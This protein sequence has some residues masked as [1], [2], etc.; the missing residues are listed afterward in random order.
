MALCFVL[1]PTEP[2][3]L[4]TVNAL[5]RESPPSGALLMQT[6]KGDMM[7]KL[8]AVTALAGLLA[9]GCSHNKSSKGGS[10]D[11]QSGMSSGGSYGQTGT[12]SGTSSGQSPSTTGSS[13]GS[14]S[15]TP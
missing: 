14:T 12:S 11:N 6:I 7:K 4:L 13:S 9:V 15:S 8:I 1:T 2:S 5:L 3:L 10:Y